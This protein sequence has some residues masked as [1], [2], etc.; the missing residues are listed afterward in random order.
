MLVVIIVYTLEVHRQPFDRSVMLMGWR[1][2]ILGDLI[3]T[4]QV[5]QTN[6][7]IVQQIASNQ[8]EVM[9]ADGTEILVSYTTPV[10]ARIPGRG[11]VRTSHKWSATTTK[12]INKWLINNRGDA[13]VPA[14]DQWEIDKLIA[15]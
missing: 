8:T 14:V 9:L 4:K 3:H 10:A 15:F 2:D 11:W 7:M 6:A 12:H 13:N 5:H 1:V